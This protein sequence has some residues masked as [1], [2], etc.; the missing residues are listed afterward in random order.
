MTNPNKLTGETVL[1]K[2]KYWHNEGEITLIRNRDLNRSYDVP[3]LVSGIKF[4]DD[5]KW[6]MEQYEKDMHD[7]LI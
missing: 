1:E 4:V 5:M 2:L 3:I 7:L 6:C